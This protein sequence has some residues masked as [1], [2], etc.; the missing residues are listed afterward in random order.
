MKTL[1]I[2][3]SLV[4]SISVMH[5]Q[6]TRKLSSFDE[7]SAATGINVVLVESNETKAVIE[8]QNCEPDEVITKISGDELIVKFENN[9]F[10]KN[11]KNRKATVTVHYDALDGISVSSGASISAENPVRSNDLEIDGSSGG[12]ITVEVEAGYLEL[13]VSSGG[14]VDIQGSAKELDCDVSS[15]GVIR[16]YDLQAESVEVDASSGGSVTIT[17]NE[18]IVAS[19][20]SG[21]S[22][23]YKGDPTRVKIDASISGSISSRN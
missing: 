7:V 17:A 5:A 6:V 12:R 2:F 11:S 18:S 14:I 21:G 8:V 3:L 13:D 20:S 9:N 22:V 23:K 19:A 10:W 15:G 1:L 4:F 16:A